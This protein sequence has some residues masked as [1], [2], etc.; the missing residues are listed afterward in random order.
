MCAL[1]FTKVSLMNVAAH[2]FG[3]LI[4]RIESSSWKILTLMS[5]KCPSLSFLITLGWKSISFDI[6]M[7]TPACFF[8]PFAWK[9]VFQPFTMRYCLSFSLRWVSC[10]Q[11]NFGSCLCSQSVSLCLFIGELNPLVLRDFKEK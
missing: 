1:S 6:R 7:L 3:A 2:E 8:R 11:Q 9:V 4:S 5:M 10:K